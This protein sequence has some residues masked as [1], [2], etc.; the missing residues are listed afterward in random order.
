MPPQRTKKPRTNGHSNGHACLLSPA[1]LLVSGLFQIC[2][3][4]CDGAKLS[5]LDG[6][7]GLAE[8]ELFSIR[9]RPQASYSAKGRDHS[10]L[11]I[12]A[13]LEHVAI[14]ISS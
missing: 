1:F 12:Q 8:V 4:E 13:S 14:E 2:A 9:S 6:F 5:K 11:I 7:Q 10:A 3:T